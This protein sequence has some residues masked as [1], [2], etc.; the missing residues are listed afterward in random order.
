MAP[1]WKSWQLS[2]TSLRDCKRHW[3]QMA[4]TVALSDAD[5][6]AVPHIPFGWCWQV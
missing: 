6:R 4:A 5:R 2:V 1:T 3:L